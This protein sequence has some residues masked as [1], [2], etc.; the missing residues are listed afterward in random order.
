MNDK[1]YDLDLIEEN[2]NRRYRL[3]KTINLVI[4]S[5]IVILGI[6]SI[7]Y[8]FDHDK[9]G[10]LTF[11]WLTVDGTLFTVIGSAIF[12]AVNL[13]E[14]IK[15]TELTAASTYYLRLAGAVAEGIIMIV[16]LL[17]QLPFFTEHM[18]IFRFDMFNMHLLIP[19]LTISSFILND[20][21]IGRLTPFQIFRGTGFVT[22]YAIIIITL[23]QSGLLTQEQIPYFFLDFHNMSV[24]MIILAFAMI[25]GI[26]YGLSYVLSALNRKLSWRWFKLIAKY[27]I[28]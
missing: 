18:H 9:E 10:V 5:V 11:R 14:M 21:S 26:G 24:W 28:K 13:V 23:I 7:A 1:K 12:I 22:V 3:K 19:L 27:T 25:Y 16:V 17:S 8:I 15:L 20:A 4:S 6:L 2:F